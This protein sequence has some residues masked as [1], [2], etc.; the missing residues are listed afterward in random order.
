MIY[1]LLQ[2][3]KLAAPPI[4]PPNSRR[5]GRG[6]G[7]GGPGG[8]A[9]DL[10][11]G[12]GGADARTHARTHTRTHMHV[13][14]HPHLGPPEQTSTMIGSEFG[15]IFADPDIPFGPDCILMIVGSV[16]ST[17]GIMMVT[18]ISV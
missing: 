4:W 13:P 15:T 2:R 10:V 3:A 12:R 6:G 9:R 8:R 16:P 11:D 14:P 17:M 5:R 18:L 7:G 1:P